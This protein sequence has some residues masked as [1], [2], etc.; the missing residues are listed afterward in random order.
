MEQNQHIETWKHQEQ[1]PFS[2]WD[3]SYLDG[4]MIAEQ[5]PWSYTSRAIDLM[6]QASSVIDQELEGT[7]MHGNSCCL[8][9][10]TTRP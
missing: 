9:R 2:G 3:F 10:W 8:H 7:I 4:R 6:H 5:A 1:Q